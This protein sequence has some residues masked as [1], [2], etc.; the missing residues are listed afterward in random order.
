MKY[1]AVTESGAIYGVDTERG[2]WRK[3]GDGWST[4]YW[5]FITFNRNA[6]A[7]LT[8]ETLNALPHANAPKIGE[9]MYFAG[10]EDWQ[11]STNVVSVEL[12]DSL[13]DI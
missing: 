2:S 3:A 4:R 8:W 7:E 9:A 1:I 6:A 12:V 10:R 11:I 5:T 13:E